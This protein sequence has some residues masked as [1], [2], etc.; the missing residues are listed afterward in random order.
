MAWVRNN[1]DIL[2]GGFITAA[3][4]KGATEA[5]TVEHDKDYVIAPDGEIVKVKN[6]GY[7]Y[8]G[9]YVVE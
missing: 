2:L 6:G 9:M 4:E 5:D 1:I 8:T 3:N 7:E